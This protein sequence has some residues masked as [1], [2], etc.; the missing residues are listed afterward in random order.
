MSK[1]SSG[2]VGGRHTRHGRRYPAAMLEA[3]VPPHT[4][5]NYLAIKVPT[6]KQFIQTRNPAITP[7]ST[8]QRAGRLER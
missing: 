7:P 5:D 3:Q 2:R 6:L 4:Q 8:H 1:P